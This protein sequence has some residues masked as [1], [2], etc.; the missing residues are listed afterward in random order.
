YPTAMSRTINKQFN[1][2]VAADAHATLKL[3]GGLLA[4]GDSNERVLLTS[5]R[6]QQPLQVTN[7]SWQEA[8][9]LLA[10]LDNRAAASQLSQPGLHLFGEVDALVP[11]AAAQA[12]GSLNSLQQVA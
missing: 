10:Q 3:F 4:Q 2:G 8:L 5:L 7:H 12:L 6:A 11:V 9:A 1:Q